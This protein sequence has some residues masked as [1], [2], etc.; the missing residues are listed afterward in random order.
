LFLFLE[1]LGK[2]HTSPLSKNCFRSKA[3]H[4]RTHTQTRNKWEDLDY[5]QD[6]ITLEEYFEALPQHFL[7]LET[8]GT[9]LAGVDQH[10]HRWP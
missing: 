3:I 2:V 7:E 9:P 8:S 6:L 10:S 4:T 5:D 1:A